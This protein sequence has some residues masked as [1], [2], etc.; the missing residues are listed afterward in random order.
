M[1]FLLTSQSLLLS[2]GRLT[3]RPDEFQCGDG[4]CI[5]GGRQCNRQYDCRDLS[6]EIGCVNG[7]LLPHI[8]LL[9]LLL[10]L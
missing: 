4:T 10:L 9:P 6:D 7:R 1:D 5:H 8:K 2:I 3:C